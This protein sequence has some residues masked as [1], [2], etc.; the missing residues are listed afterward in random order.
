MQCCAACPRGQYD[1]PRGAVQPP[2]QI[3]NWLEMPKK[4]P[5]ILKQLP[6]RFIDNE[7]VVQNYL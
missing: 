3:K 4:S 7:H 1:C 5:Y 2:A 6:L